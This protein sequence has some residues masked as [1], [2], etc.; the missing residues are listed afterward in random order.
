MESSTSGTKKGPDGQT[1]AEAYT[2]TTRSLLPE[3]VEK[4]TIEHTQYPLVFST[5]PRPLAR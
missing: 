1:I 4:L 2:I 3:A 5:Y